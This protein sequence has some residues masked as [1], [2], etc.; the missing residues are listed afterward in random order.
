MK[1]SGVRK[2]SHSA[3][4]V[5]VRMARTK[6]KVAMEMQL[7][8]LQIRFNE[9]SNAEQLKLVVDVLTGANKPVY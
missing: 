6:E 9:S 5:P 7:G 8:D 4:V 1:D 3:A 2:P